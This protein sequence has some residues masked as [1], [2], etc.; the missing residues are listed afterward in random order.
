MRMIPEQWQEL[1][2]ASREARGRAYAPY[3][4]YPVGAAV[5]TASG[6]IFAGCN[7]ENSSYGNTI[8]AERVAVCSAVAEGHREFQAIVVSLTGVAVPC[9][10]CRQFLYEFNPEMMVLLD[11]LTGLNTPELSRSVSQ[12]SLTPPEVVVLK[13]LLP[14]GFRLAQS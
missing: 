8:C 3:S 12:S 9:G 1:V 7:V 5:L 6:R 4:Q 14:R 10:T 13:D 2:A 11:D